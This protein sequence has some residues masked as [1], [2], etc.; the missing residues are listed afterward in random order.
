M[1]IGLRGKMDEFGRL[2]DD[3]ESAGDLYKASGL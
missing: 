2:M 3:L 1:L